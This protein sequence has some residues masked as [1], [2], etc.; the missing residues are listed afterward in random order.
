MTE[1][2][3]SDEFVWREHLMRRHAN[4]VESGWLFVKD[5]NAGLEQFGRGDQKRR[6]LLEQ[7][8]SDLNL[9]VKTLQNMMAMFR[10][11]AATIATELNVEHGANLS[12]YHADAV[13][14]LHP[15][16]AREILS[17]AAE[18]GWSAERTRQ[19]AWGNRIPG[20]GKRLLDV[21]SQQEL[22]SQIR[23][24]NYKRWTT[25]IG[26]TLPVVMRTAEHEA[27]AIYGRVA[28][29]A[30]LWWMADHCLQIQN[31]ALHLRNLS[32]WTHARYLSYY[33]EQRAL[34]VELYQIS[35][36]DFERCAETARLFPQERRRQ[37]EVLT[38]RHHELIAT[39]SRTE[40]DYYL[41]LANRNGWT[42]EQLAIE[43]KGRQS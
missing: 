43:L 42:A 17:T 6:E 10:S 28:I 13:N 29:D 26:A 36:D 39:R 22:S 33:N 41:D 1:I 18:Q 38:Y 24:V 5:L 25:T 15:G 32:R 37:N 23:E 19:A 2:I 31:Q 4:L 3:Y 9:S 35:N 14:G 16:V 7:V 11:P 30:A 21:D 34:L 27:L 20:D 12:I 8:A 40:Q